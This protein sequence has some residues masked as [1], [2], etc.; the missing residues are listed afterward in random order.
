MYV[1]PF[2]VVVAG[3]GCVKQIICRWEADFWFHNIFLLGDDTVLE[4]IITVKS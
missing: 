4:M 1:K 3:G 2:I